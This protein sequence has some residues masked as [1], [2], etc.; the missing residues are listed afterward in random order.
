MAKEYA[1]KFYHRKAWKDCKRSFISDRVAVDGGMCQVCHEKLG[2]IV[3]HRT[4]ITADNISDP[5]ITLN[6]NNWEYVC[7]DC[8]DMF[9]GHGVN[10]KRQSLLVMFDENG[11]PIAKL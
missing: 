8:H 9:E 4:H 5:D 7:K 1:D 2:Y 6:H 3:H 10:N 11:Q